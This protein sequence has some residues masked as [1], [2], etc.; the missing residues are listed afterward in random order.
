MSETTAD[1]SHR[2]A[3]GYRLGG[4][5]LGGHVPGRSIAIALAISLAATLAAAGLFAL[6][7]AKRD[8]VEAAIEVPV[9]LVKL[10]PDAAQQ[11]ID[12]LAGW[13][14][15]RVY[16]AFE[17]TEEARIHDILAQ[18]TD[19]PA[20]EELYLQRRAAIL[21]SGLEKA[22]QEVHELEIL[23]ASAERED[24]QLF[25]RVQWRVL[26][27]VGHAEHK[28]RR[29]NAYSADM[30]FNRVRGGWKIVAFDLR[31]VDRREAGAIV[32]APDEPSQPGQGTSPE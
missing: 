28:H 2:L 32:D 9:E 10:A 17:E 13:A 19:G 31:E 7:S 1:P 12:E 14:L 27:L 29:G 15:E 22:G 18:A 4:S 23:S 3:S 16:R 24:N 30:I 5:K 6:A 11:R 21:Q 25:A 26:G 8:A 20:L